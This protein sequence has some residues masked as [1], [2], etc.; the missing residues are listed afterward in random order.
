[1]ARDHDFDVFADEEPTEIHTGDCDATP[2]SVPTGDA[3]VNV[4]LS[5]DRYAAD[6]EQFNTE[7]A[8]LDD[9]L[10]RERPEA[11]D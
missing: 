7:C 1:M 5:P 6:S 4:V 3:T 9:V 11:D 8:C 10:G 2:A